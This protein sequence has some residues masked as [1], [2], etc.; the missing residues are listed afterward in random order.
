[1]RHGGK[2]RHLPVPLR[3]PGRNHS[4]RGIFC[5]V[6]AFGIAPFPVEGQQGRLFTEPMDQDRRDILAR[7]GNSM[8]DYGAS[9]VKFCADEDIAAEKAL[10]NF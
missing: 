2:D 5:A 9:V 7:C 1:M 10:E 8:G 6:L 3:M 4:R